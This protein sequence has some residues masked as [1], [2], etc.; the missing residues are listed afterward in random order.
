MASNRW[1]LFFLFYDCFASW[2]MCVLCTWERTVVRVTGI[3]YLSL[4]IWSSLVQSP[5]MSGHDSKYFSTTKKGEIPE[6]KEEL[7]SQYKVCFPLTL[8]PHTIYIS[9]ERFQDLYFVV[10]FFLKNYNGT[11]FWNL[12]VE[13]MWSC[14]AA[15]ISPCAG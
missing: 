15:L 6:L 1:L 7:N 11:F 13:C 4:C 14:I 12:T 10:F 2:K 9:F 8:Y 3:K 5:A